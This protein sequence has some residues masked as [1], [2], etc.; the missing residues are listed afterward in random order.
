MVHQSTRPLPTLTKSVG[1]NWTFTDLDVAGLDVFGPRPTFLHSGPKTSTIRGKVDY[2]G[3][4][5]LVMNRVF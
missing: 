3:Q 5:I 2:D 4:A 1:M